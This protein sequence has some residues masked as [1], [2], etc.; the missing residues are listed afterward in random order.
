MHNTFILRFLFITWFCLQVFFGFSQ[1]K[2]YCFSL[3][4]GVAQPLGAF[5]NKHPSNSSNSFAEKGVFIEFFIIKRVTEKYG[6]FVTNIR[7][8]HQTNHQYFLDNISGRTPGAGDI[9][10][11]DWETANLLIGFLRF[12]NLTEKFQLES[13]LMIGPHRSFIGEFSAYNLD[14]PPGTPRSIHKNGIGSAFALGLGAKTRLKYNLNDKL[15]FFSNV[16]FL[17]ANPSFKDRQISM[18]F[19]RTK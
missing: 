4:F 10:E 17:W 14:G 8:I 12:F 5:A 6:Y 16:D 3:N 1:T 19:D 11:G 15:C 9:F 7:T 2:D 18:N 13:G